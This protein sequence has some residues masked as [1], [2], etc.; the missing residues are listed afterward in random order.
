MRWVQIDF[1]VCESDPVV[2]VQWLVS[3]SDPVVGVQSHVHDLYGQ[4]PTRGLCA[5]PLAS[6]A[7]PRFRDRFSS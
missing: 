6:P 5:G 4:S 7:L 2:G 3:Q 1:F